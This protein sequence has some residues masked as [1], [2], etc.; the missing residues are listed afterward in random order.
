M[1]QCHA[2][3]ERVAWRAWTLC[4]ASIV[5][6]GVCIWHC[7]IGLVALS[8]SM[9]RIVVGHDGGGARVWAPGIPTLALDGS[10]N[11]GTDSDAEA[12]V[13]SRRSSSPSLLFKLA[14][15]C[16]SV[17]LTRILVFC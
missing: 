12:A 11:H 2:R 8:L 7:L 17:S 13:H 14:I 10:G 5:V 9:G 15:P 1:G 3:V 4:I 6:C 16:G